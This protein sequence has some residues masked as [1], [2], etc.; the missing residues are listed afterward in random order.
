[1]SHNLG[2]GHKYM[3]FI[4]T[5][6]FTNETPQS[7]MDVCYSTRDTIPPQLL[8]SNGTWVA[9]KTTKEHQFTIDACL[10]TPAFSTHTHGLTELGMPEFLMDLLSFGADGT[11]SRIKWSYE[12]FVKP[13]NVGKLDAIKNGETVKLSII[14][15]KPDATPE[16]YVY[17]YRRVY[18]EL[19]MV[20]MA[21]AIESPT[22]VDPSMSFIQIYI[23]GDDFALKDDYYKGGIK[24]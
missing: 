14:D 19:E 17:C 18:P 15:L 16:T 8:G 22:D 6:I 4:A 13:E 9:A 24:W 20:K 1:M 3:P 11:G 10:E 2:V 7:I 12:Y 23:E 5:L 21:Y